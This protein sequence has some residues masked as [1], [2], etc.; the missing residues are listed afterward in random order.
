MANLVTEGPRELEDETAEGDQVEIGH[1]P[2][3]N[4]WVDCPNLMIYADDVVLR[5]E[6]PWDHGRRWRRRNHA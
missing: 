4:L 6:I 1:E 2:C 5:V 3:P